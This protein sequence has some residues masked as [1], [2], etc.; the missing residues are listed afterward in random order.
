MN[1]LSTL[2]PAEV[3]AIHDANLTAKYMPKDFDPRQATRTLV[4]AALS[5]RN[6]VPY[7]MH[8]LPEEHLAVHERHLRTPGEPVPSYREHAGHVA[9]LRSLVSE[10]DHAA[11]AKARGTADAKDV[12]DA[13]HYAQKQHGIALWAETDRLVNEHVGPPT[14]P[15]GT[16]SAPSGKAV[17]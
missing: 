8:C 5:E 14:A 3:K 6:P 2:E 11:F 15:S 7:G 1:T 13:H 12:H 10:E 4:H 16:A 9:I 17:G